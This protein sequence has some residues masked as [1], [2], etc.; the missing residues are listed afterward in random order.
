MHIKCLMGQINVRVFNFHITWR[1]EEEEKKNEKRRH[2]KKL[3]T[4]IVYAAR[5]T[6]PTFLRE[7]RS[8][9]E[10]LGLCQGLSRFRS[11]ESPSLC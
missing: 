5:F 10:D 3:R 1:K 2:K 6:A 4:W 11:L 8:D 9:A 7:T